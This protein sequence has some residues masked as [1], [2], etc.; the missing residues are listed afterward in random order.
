MPVWSIQYS[1]IDLI[2]IINATNGPNVV[3]YALKL[4]KVLT[5]WHQIF[6]KLVFI[7][8]TKDNLFI[9]NL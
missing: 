5:S 9:T 1:R 6:N 4:I 8:M 3:E 2:K 7:F